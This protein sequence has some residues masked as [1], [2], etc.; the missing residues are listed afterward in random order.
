[1]VRLTLSKHLQR[2]SP[3]MRKMLKGQGEEDRQ[4]D[5]PIRYETLA[6]SQPASAPAPGSVGAA[7]Q[8]LQKLDPALPL[9]FDCPDCGKGWVAKTV[10]FSVVVETEMVKKET[11]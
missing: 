8:M 9:Y 10:R 5:L 7:I 4:I 3:R 11:I 6:T 1:M 2:I